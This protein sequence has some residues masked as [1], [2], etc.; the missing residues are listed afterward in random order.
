MGF[1]C[2]HVGLPLGS[3][4]A[5]VQVFTMRREMHTDRTARMGCYGFRVSGLPDA[6]DLLLEAAPTWPELAV[7]RAE[8]D[9]EPPVHDQVGDDRARLPL[10]GGGWMEV[11][12]GTV[13]FRAVRRRPD[14]DLVHPYLAPGAALAARW[15]G[16]D[17]FHAGALVAGG[18]AWCV[19]GGKE[20]GKST[21]LAWLALHGH[22]VLSDDLLV[23]DGGEA[24][25]GPRCVDLREEAAGRLGTGDALG[26]V[27][28]RERW[29]VRLGPAPAAV[30]LRGWVLLEWG[31]ALAVEPV[32]GPD[33]LLALP[34]HRSVQLA[35]AAPETLLALSSLP[36]WRFRRPRRWDAIGDGAER[37]LAALAG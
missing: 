10:A 15:A 2:V 36:V 26:V 13:T 34:P 9:G 29:R 6:A 33:R 1:I 35:P 32:R 12:P 16:R 7:A 30:P 3:G 22:Q 24:M 14:G 31:D 5:Q 27:G 28:V 18:G 37:L 23:V 21:L 25:A 17:S 11:T 19:L 8:P 4:H 20:D